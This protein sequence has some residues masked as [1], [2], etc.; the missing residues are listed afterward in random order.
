MKT[1]ALYA[2]V[3]T[4]DQNCDLQ[5]A[6]LRRYARQRFECLREYVDRG[7]SGTQRHRPQL[8]VL[9]KDA[10]KR[11]FDVVLVWKFDRFARSLKHLIDRRSFEPWAL[12]SSATP[13]V[14]TPPRRPG[15]CCSTWW[16]RWHSLS[17][18]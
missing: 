3:S 14:S 16:V 18:I 4:L 1:A 13:K 8:D 5:L 7:I 17:G 9:V 12:I 11:M 15:S 2:R 10:R 6:D